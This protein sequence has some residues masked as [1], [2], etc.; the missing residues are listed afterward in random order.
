[1]LIT[2]GCA[3]AQ[4]L[5]EVLKLKCQQGCHLTGNSPAVPIV[6]LLFPTRI[7]MPSGS[8][9]RSLYG[10]NDIHTTSRGQ[11]NGFSSA[12]TTSIEKRSHPAAWWSEYG[13]QL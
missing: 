13:I 12:Q 10:H 7:N 4:A 6:Q 2:R 3:R 8:L 11:H 1:V 9:T 5:S